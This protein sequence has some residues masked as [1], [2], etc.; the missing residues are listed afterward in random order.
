[1][2][3][4]ALCIFLCMFLSLCVCVRAH[5]HVLVGLI[6]SA[7]KPIPYFPLTTEG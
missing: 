7:T 5:A 1:M 2:S 4:C 6:I 3:L